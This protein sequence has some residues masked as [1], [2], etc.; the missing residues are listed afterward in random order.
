MP[1]IVAL[2]NEFATVRV[3]TE[4][5]MIHHEFKQY[6]Y[7]PRLREA[8]TVGAELMEQHKAIRWL[9]DDRKNGPLPPADADWAKNVWFPRV[10]K[11][12]WKKWAVVV[13]EMVLGQMN[14]QMFIDTYQ[15][16]G[17]EAKVFSNADEAM[18]WLTKA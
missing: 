1:T 11:A 8:L 6:I 14:I 10:V 12:G 9:S 17:I 16:Q 2:D 4:K 18:T 3:V 15:K 13:P 7:G 5:R